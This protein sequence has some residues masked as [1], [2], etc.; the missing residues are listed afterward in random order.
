MD[1][2]RTHR[3]TID[4]K[5]LIDIDVVDVRIVKESGDGHTALVQI[6]NHKHII[7]EFWIGLKP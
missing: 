6:E 7:N 1:K 3:I 2:G 4:E 5:Q